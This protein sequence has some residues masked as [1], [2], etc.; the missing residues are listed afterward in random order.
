MSSQKRD[1]GPLV[2]VL[3]KRHHHVLNLTL[4]VELSHGIHGEPS[5]VGAAAIGH[6]H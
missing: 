2:G 4:G 6:T 3:G 5:D 1:I